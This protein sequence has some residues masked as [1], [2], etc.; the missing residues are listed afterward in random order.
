MW[1]F[2]FARKRPIHLYTLHK[3]VGLST[4]DLVVLGAG[5]KKEGYGVGDG[6]RKRMLDG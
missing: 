6:E 5:K 3:I 2:M 1:A 4:N